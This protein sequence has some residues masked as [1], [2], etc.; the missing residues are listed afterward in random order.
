MLQLSGNKR[1]QRRT[2]LV[3]RRRGEEA[4]LDG[5][6]L[7]DEDARRLMELGFLPGA[8]VVAGCS[9][10]GGGPT[11][12]A[13]IK[14]FPVENV[15]ESEAPACDWRLKTGPSGLNLALMGVPPCS[16]WIARKSHS[17]G[18]PLCG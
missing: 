6:D 7:P 13:K 14:T 2:T 3:D 5:L 1:A 18:K 4:I 15:R 17:A 10:P 11:I 9:A 16:E 12:S 8:R